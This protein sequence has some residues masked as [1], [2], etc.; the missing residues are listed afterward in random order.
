MLL[1]SAGG[2][3]TKERGCRALSGNL[4]GRSSLESFGRRVVGAVD[5][6]L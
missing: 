5:G 2:R 3:G 6:A 4:Q 1:R